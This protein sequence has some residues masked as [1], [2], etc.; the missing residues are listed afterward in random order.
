M[1]RAQYAGDIKL[2]GMLHAKVLRSPHPHA[3]IVRVDTSAAKALPGVKLVVTGQEVPAR[4]W[5]PHRKEQRILAC[6]VVRHVGEE[7]AAVV[8]VSEEIARDALDLV[9]IEYEAL[10]ALLTPAAALA[11]GAP[12]I[13]AGTRN[14]GH[15]MHIVRGDVDAAFEAC[16]AVYEATYD[17]HSQYPAISSRWPRWRRRTATGGSRC[18]PRPSPCSSRARGWPRRWS[19]RSRPS[20]GAGHHRRRL[21]RQDRRGEQ[22]P[23]LRLPGQPAGAPVRLVNNRLED[24]QGARAACRCG[25]GCAWGCRQTA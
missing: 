12:E 8:A 5:G 9:R 11:D 3:R 20:R 14:V 7:V 24:F 18:G 19:G 4:N 10:P 6:G 15:E 22:Q 2:P 23:D 16:A 1:G 17:M 13:H 21:R 25:S